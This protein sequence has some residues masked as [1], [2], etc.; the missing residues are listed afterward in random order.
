MTGDVIS[1]PMNTADQTAKAG[2]RTS[3]TSTSIFLW[4][5]WRDTP[6]VQSDQLCS[7]G[8][9]MTSATSLS[10]SIYKLL[11]YGL[12]T[13]TALLGKDD[14]SGA[15]LNQHVLCTL[16]NENL[17]IEESIGSCLE[18]TINLVNLAL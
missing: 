10:L 11:L 2:C 12:S 9:D 8:A 4:L 17:Y 16:V 3:R 7:I 18:E 14:K 15:E 5:Y 13:R 1:A 6:P